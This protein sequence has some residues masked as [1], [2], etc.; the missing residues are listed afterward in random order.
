[1]TMG[2]LRLKNHS[3]V[4][5]RASCRRRSQTFRFALPKEAER[6]GSFAFMTAGAR[7][8]HISLRDFKVT[9]WPEADVRLLAPAPVDVGTDLCS[10]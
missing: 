10:G 2:V 4:M 3:G 8:F 7:G 9:V 5:A 1:M 6:L